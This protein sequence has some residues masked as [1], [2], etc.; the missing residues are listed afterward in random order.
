[1]R[2]C[3]LALEEMSLEQQPCH[4]FQLCEADNV[5]L[6][7]LGHGGSHSLVV[8]VA[9]MWGISQLSCKVSVYPG[10][11]GWCFLY[12]PIA[13]HCHDFR[14]CWDIK[15]FLMMHLQLRQPLLGHFVRCLLKSLIVSPLLQLIHA[16]IWQWASYNFLVHLCVW[17][18]H[19]KVKVIFHGLFQFLFCFLSIILSITFTVIAD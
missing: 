7:R 10:Q 19:F 13:V 11:W 9:V 12:C 3:A 8:L 17:L 14:D 18:S 16:A 1:M 5:F 4:E 15:I 6:L 2:L